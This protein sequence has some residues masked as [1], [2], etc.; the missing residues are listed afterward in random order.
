MAAKNGLG[1][2]AVQSVP[3][4]MDVAGARVGVTAGAARV[5]GL[6]GADDEEPR[7]VAA[8]LLAEA[9]GGSALRPAVRSTVGQLRR[10][11]GQ[12]GHEEHPPPI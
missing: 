1:H 7:R 3:V 8:A 10:R 9:T 12:V 11:A 6:G 5:A 2:H 4:Q